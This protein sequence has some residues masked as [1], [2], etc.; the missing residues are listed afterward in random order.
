MDLRYD[1]CLLRL[2]LSL[3]LTVFP[4]W[5]VPKRFKKK[6]SG[7]LTGSAVQ[8]ARGPPGIAPG[9]TANIVYAKWSV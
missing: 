5:C 4:L 2:S 7:D 1:V 9:T 3:S 8:I 6:A